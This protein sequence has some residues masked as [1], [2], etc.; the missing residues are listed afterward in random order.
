LTASERSEILLRMRTRSLLFALALAA[1]L[2]LPVASAE[3]TLYSFGSPISGAFPGVLC[4]SPGGTWIN[5]ALAE[6]GAGLTAPV[7]GAIVRWRMAG[8]Y[9]GGPF[10]L[11]VLR[12][13]GGGKYT[14]VASSPEVSPTTGSGLL[15]FETAIPVQAGDTIGL[16]VHE[17]CVGV[18]GISGSH[19]NNWNPDIKEG[20]S[21]A[22][23]YTNYPNVEAGFDA[24]VQ[25]PPVIGAISPA[26]VPTAGG[27]AVTISG[28]NFEG[29]SAVSF[30]GVPAAFSRESSSQIRASVPAGA[31]G[32]V[33]VVV[34]TPAGTASAPFTYLGA[35]APLPVSA[36]C[37]VP[38]LGGKKLKAAKKLLKAGDC[39]PGKVSKHK[40]I[41]AADGKVVHQSAKAGA[42]LAAGTKVKLTLG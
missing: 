39:K 15:S 36:Q 16:D 18:A 22:P 6:P 3:A 34:T 33:A 2:A 20:D 5:T 8:A 17:G 35:A 28:Q 31:A 41:T 37:V 32:A 40:G 30:A 4:S 12:P 42:K 7:S 21:S 23:T 13:V 1:L 11:R 27:V 26:A 14:A 29:A 24:F 25:P 38:R 19:M 9:S 10:K